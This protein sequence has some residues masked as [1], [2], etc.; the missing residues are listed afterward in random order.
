[1]ELVVMPTPIVNDQQ[2]QARTVASAK[3]V[4]LETVKFAG[5]IAIWTVGLTMTYPAPMT[6]VARTIASTHPIQDK[7]TP[8]AMVLEMLAMMMPIT[9]VSP[10]LPT[11]AH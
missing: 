11:I 3:L 7:K 2:E 1:M 5:Q 9:M 4:M 8:I 10:I 6:N